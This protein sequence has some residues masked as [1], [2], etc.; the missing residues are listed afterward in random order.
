MTPLS[1]R[2]NDV[3]PGQDISSEDLQPLLY[4]LSQCQD[5]FTRI[6]GPGQTQFLT[7]LVERAINFSQSLSYIRQQYNLL[8]ELSQRAGEVR[9]S[10]KVLSGAGKEWKDAVA[11]CQKFDRLHELVGDVAF[12]A[13]E[14][15]GVLEE[16]YQSRRLMYQQK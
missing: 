12:F 10:I 1:P 8:Q 4:V 14:G 2:S 9:D 13:S 3:P 15:D 5:D 6:V 16:A 7:K 11:S